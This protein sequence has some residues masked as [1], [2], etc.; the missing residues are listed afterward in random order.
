MTTTSRPLGSKHRAW[1]ALALAASLT[2][3]SAVANADT[4]SDLKEQTETLQRKVT[5][6]ENSQQKAAPNNAVTGGSTPGSFKLPGSDTSVK[7]GGYVK[8]DAI[9]SNITQGVDAVA[10]QQTVD[11]A[12]P[13]PM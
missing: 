5:E 6:L 1:S 13:F 8:L 3:A 9:Y 10:N 4:L 11:S 2:G 12:I 7:L